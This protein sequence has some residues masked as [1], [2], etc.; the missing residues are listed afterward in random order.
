MELQLHGARIDD[1]SNRGERRILGE[2]ERSRS[3]PAAKDWVVLHSVRIKP[4]AYSNGGEVDVV[5][6]MPDQHAV[7]LLEIKGHESVEEQGER[8]QVRYQDGSRKDPLA[9]VDKARGAVLSILQQAR[10]ERQIRDDA[11]VHVVTGVLLPFATLGASGG[12]PWD[13]SQIVD[14]RG[15][16]AGL[17]E[18]IVRMAEYGASGRQPPASPLHPQMRSFLRDLFQPRFQPAFDPR[19]QVEAAEREALELTRQQAQIIESIFENDHRPHVIHGPAGS[20]KTV[21]AVD[22]LCRYRDEHPEER[23]LFLCFNAFLAQKVQASSDGRFEASTIHK[24]MSDITRNMFT[25]SE[26]DSA[27]YLE[28]ILPERAALVALDEEIKY[29]LIVLDEYPDAFSDQVLTFLDCLLEGGFAE[30]RWHFLGDVQQDVFKRDVRERLSAFEKRYC[31]AR[32]PY[33]MTLNENLRNTRQIAELGRRILRDPH[34][35]AVRPDGVSVETSGYAALQPALQREVRRWLALGYRPSEIVVITP[36]PSQIDV[37][38]DGHTIQRISS[39]DGEAALGSTTAR[40]YKGC[41]SPVVVLVDPQDTPA[42]DDEHRRQLT[43]V[44]VT[45]AKHGL[46][47]LYR[48]DRRAAF[49]ALWSSG[50]P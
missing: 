15:I 21:L 5:V 18:A 14:E 30:G 32:A 29:D 11:F 23:I 8:I 39:V 28:R 3:H 19:S 50:T 7:V 47:V 20:G 42:T 9:Q 4:Y 10:R 43:Y 38:V 27:D 41:E 1:V 37:T 17:V 31:P 45:R 22:L 36:V 33:R 24:F 2:L 35:R 26:R 40:K 44:A 6:I 12:I 34:I 49:D 25:R 48:T 16:N 46:S 13:R